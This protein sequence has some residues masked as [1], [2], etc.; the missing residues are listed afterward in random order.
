MTA[1]Q[2]GQSGHHHGEIVRKPSAGPDL[3]LWLTKKEAADALGMS[4]RTLDR[5]CDK[6]QGPERRDRPVAGGGRPEAVYNPDDVERI[7][8]AKVGQV[9]AAASPLMP[10]GDAFAPV[11]DAGLAI[12]RVALAIAD[13]IA[14]PDRWL[15]LDDAAAHKGLSRALILR[16]VKAG[17]LPA[18]RDRAIK[19]RQSD[20]DKIITLSI[21]SEYTPPLFRPEKRRR[22][23][24]G[25]ETLTAPFAG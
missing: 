18:I 2:T 7:R 20:L 23:S 1:E 15:T 11:K 6:K 8:A 24:N 4:E 19:V 13:R 10:L 3:G 14:P 25:G 9:I 12:E 22:P 5:L 21:L 16:L 17:V